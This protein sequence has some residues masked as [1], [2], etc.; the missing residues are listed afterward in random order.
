MKC[1]HVFYYFIARSFL[2]SFFLSFFL[3]SLR[4]RIGVNV[5]FSFNEIRVS[6]NISFFFF[7]SFSFLKIVE[8]ISQHQGQDRK[9]VV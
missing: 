5:D 7:L 8:L 1:P 6:L 2:P 9:S 4:V 3:R